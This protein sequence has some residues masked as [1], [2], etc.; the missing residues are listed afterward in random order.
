MASQ[1][2][3]PGPCAEPYRMRAI[4][5][6]PDGM[7]EA[8]RCGVREAKPGTL[9]TKT[10]LIA[11]G[12]G[13]VA[14]VLISA[15]VIGQKRSPQSDGDLQGEVQVLDHG[16]RISLDGAGRLRSDFAFT[17]EDSEL[18]EQVLHQRRLPLALKP[19]ALPKDEKVFA[20]LAPLG[21]KTS[22]LPEFE[23]RKVEGASRYQVT[24][25]DSGGQT[26]A[27]SPRVEATSWVAEKPLALSGE[28][29]WSVRAETP[30]GAMEAQPAEKRFVTTTPGDM[31]SIQHARAKGSHLLL[32]AVFAR[33][34]MRSEAGRELEELR[35]ENRESALLRSLQDSLQVAH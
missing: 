25:Q 28:Y 15:V 21:E 23:W 2:H 29:T 7:M 32:A 16:K 17:A 3:D 27:Q 33:L 26:V 24:V 18:L 14:A 13:A 19:V 8:A 10:V 11:M 1:R 12:L 9:S 20:A 6:K 35:A 22:N 5:G 30:A 31:D 4:A 34:G